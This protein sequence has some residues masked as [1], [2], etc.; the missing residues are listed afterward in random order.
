LLTGQSGKSTRSI[1]PRAL[2]A[3]LVMGSGWRGR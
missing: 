3:Q 1:Y 2:P